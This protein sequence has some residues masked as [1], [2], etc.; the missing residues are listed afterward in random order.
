MQYATDQ[1]GIGT[2]ILPGKTG[3]FWMKYTT[4]VMMRIPTFTLEAPTAQE[5]QT[6]LWKGRVAVAS[7]LL[8]PDESHPTNASLYICTDSSYSLEKLSANARRNVRHGLRELKITSLTS[9]QVLAHGER[10]FCDTRRRVGLSDGTPQEFRQRFIGRSRLPEHVYFGAWKDDQLAAFLSITEVDDWAEIEGSFSMDA[11]LELRPND[12]L[13]Y[14]VLHHY[15]VERNYRKVSYGV[16]SIQ[17]ESNAVGLHRFKT[18]LGLQAQPVYRA[19]AIHPLLRPFA[20]RVALRLIN[21]ALSF[22]PGNPYLKKVEGMLALLI[23]DVREV[24]TASSD[25]GDR[26]MGN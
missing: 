2:R 14:S 5:I 12:A 17:A 1:A 20:N 21:R 4:G 22:R 13:N 3:T 8:E 7:Y 16:S 25:V 9:E 15:L 19:F 11:L 6:I 23:G 18:K 10:A 24:D 26:T